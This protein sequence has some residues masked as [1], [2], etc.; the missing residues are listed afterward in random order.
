MCTYSRG[1]T[2][3]ILLAGQDLSQDTAHDLTRSSLG[4]VIDREDGL[5][6]CEGTDGLADLHDEVLL[7]RVAVLVTLLERHEGVDGLTGELVVD[8]YDSS[9]GDCIVLEERS[10]YLRCR[11]TVTG[12]VDDIIDS[13]ADPVVALGVAGGSVTC[14]LLNMSVMPDLAS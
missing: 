8:T 7:D 6:S 9:L 3:L 5:R 12:N 14:E 11:E 10:L 13:A 4:Q 2:E 1:V